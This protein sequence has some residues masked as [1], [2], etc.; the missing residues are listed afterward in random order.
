MYFSLWYIEEHYIGRINT[1]TDNNGFGENLNSS[2]NTNNLGGNLGE[3]TGLNGLGQGQT[4]YNTGNSGGVNLNKDGVQGQNPNYKYNANAN[5]NYQ[6][7]NANMN[8]Q[9]PNNMGMNN[10]YQQQ[11]N[12]S[13]LGGLFGDLDPNTQYIIWLVSG[14]I[15]IINIC[16]CNV[17][18]LVFGILTVIFCSKAKQGIYSNDRMTFEHNI[19]TARLLSLIGWIVIVLNVILNIALGFFSAVMDKF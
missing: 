10:G 11:N 19:K 5:Y 15:Q 3:P 17:F 1:M 9:N 12:N 7:G 18:S 8:Y 14:I 13:G 6:N 16:C 2:A 4:N